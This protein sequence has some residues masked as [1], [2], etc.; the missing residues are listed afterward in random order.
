V[1]VVSW[2]NGEIVTATKVSGGVEHCLQM[3]LMSILHRVEMRKRTSMILIQ[4][5]LTTSKNKMRQL[6]WLKLLLRE[7]RKTSV[8]RHRYHRESGKVAVA[9]VVVA[10][11]AAAVAETASRLR[12][13]K[14]K[15][16]LEITASRSRKM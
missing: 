7:R 2:M 3:K 14:E 5:C 6:H 15:R 1:A 11:A 13:M 8:A 16:V 12:K 4:K 9:V 10:A